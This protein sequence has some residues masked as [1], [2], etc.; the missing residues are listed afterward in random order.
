MRFELL[1]PVRLGDDH[2]GSREIRGEMPRT[3]LALL[4][5]N[6]N[7][8]VSAD[9]LME[10]VWAGNA[11]ASARESLQNHV[12]RLRRTLGDEGG[13]RIRAVAPGYLIQVEPGEFDLEVFE[14]LC[15]SGAQSLSDWQWASAS[16]DLTAALALWRG[17]PAADVPAVSGHP[18]IRE[19][20]ESRLEALEGRIEADLELGRHREVVGELS[21]LVAEHTLHEGFHRQL[22]LALYREDRQ[23]EALDTFLALRRALVDGPGTQPGESI[24]RLQG[25]ILSAAPEIAAPVRVAE[26]T[27][28]AQA[29]GPTGTTHDNA[30]ANADGGSRF[31]LP[32]DPRGF[33]GRAHELDEL[34]ALA[35]AAPEGTDAGMV[36]IS[37]IDG[38]GGVG[39]TALAVCAAHRVRDRFPDG[40]LF[41]DLHGFSTDLDPIT[42]AD[43]LDW[44]LRSLGVPP[45]LIPED[46]G[47]RAAAYRDRLNGTRTLI[48][49]DNAA[50]AAQV[51]PLLP[52]APGCLVLIT[53]RKQLTGL[54]DAYALALDVLPEA[55]AIALLHRIAGSGRV[56]AHHPAIPEL[57]AL[58]GQLPLAVRII[59][60]RLRQ[61]P[62]LR[63]EDLVVRLRD[64]NALLDRLTGDDHNLT[65]VFD[66]S[67]TNLP[68]AEQHLFRNLGL[69]PGPDF[70]TYAAANLIDT[71]LRATEHLLESLLSHSLLIQ[72][73]P[74][75]YR[76]HDLVRAYARTLSSDHPADADNTALD[77]LMDYYQHTSDSAD[78]HLARLT[79]PGSASVALD[80]PHLSVLP[81][82]PDRTAAVAWMR[83]ERE[84]LL[85]A[86]AHA[87]ASAQPERM[88]A[89]TSALAAFL[90]QEG[91]WQQAAALHQA[92]VTT[93]RHHRDLVGE[94][95]A[96]QDLSRVRLVTGDHAAAAKLFERALTLYRDL[97]DRLG[98]AN[99]ECELSRVHGMTGDFPVAIS[100]TEHALA[101]YQD[102]GD[103]LGEANARQDLARVHGARGDLPAST[104]FLKQAV[105]LYHEVGHRHG[106]AGALRELASLLRLS[107]DFS[108]A[109]DLAEQSLAE[110]RDLGIRQ[111]EGN[112]LRE[113]S[114]I[115]ELSG[116]LTPAADLLELALKCYRDL[117]DRPGEA[118]A[119]QDLGS[120]RRKTGDYEGAADVLEQALALYRDLGGRL[121]EANTLH[122]LGDLRL[123]TGDLST[124]A[125]LLEQ[126][127]ALFLDLGTRLGEADALQSLGRVRH[128]ARDYRAAA[129]LF[130]RS[131]ALF[132]ELGDP[133]GEADVLNRYGALVAD[134]VG[135]EEAIDLFQQ[136]LLLARSLNS[137]I[138]EAHALEGTARCLAGIHGREAALAD[139][140][141]AV[142]I[143]ERIGVTEAVAAAAYLADL[144]ARLRLDE[145]PGD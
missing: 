75:R 118:N 17:R 107:G 61:E 133:Q 91:H 8:V 5:L 37:A 77:R 32:P 67:Y 71:D 120:L 140:T 19:A 83:A 97:G 125:D 31:Q 130:E 101:L 51:R 39:K 141:E 21:V 104:D 84:N 121:G 20:I 81:D 139:L 26:A 136:A 89:L 4:L 137:P 92:A 85:A 90:Q 48:V 60:A 28:V 112:A 103:R 33:T 142:T 10:T 57:I 108:G 65:A 44:F 105:A 62:S 86:I 122:V 16:G 64:E 145:A 100:L 80:L 25:Q 14:A 22:M 128:A 53:S 27:T 115:R 12:M 69:I 38:M 96:L 94:A 113:L 114:N 1:G 56:P 54:D 134:S 41:L 36:V 3:V 66:S 45:K 70:D 95:N 78:R 127:L 109:T 13:A 35:G 82:L 132:R 46:L 116:D 93:A 135:P 73:T 52:E 23:A 74:G 18:R 55:D 117:G 76:F 111:G 126:C 47:E 119:L 79:R 124:A 63:I 58:C 6:A 24:R 72:Q 123:T 43:A 138:D 9:E 7:A 131:L 40:Q 143:Y 99:T 129:D 88:I 15:A 98:E 30:N 34:I 87:A 49:L 2:S 106:L 42:A 29:A 110:Y 68:D 102:L 59:A 144:R 50:G 11:P